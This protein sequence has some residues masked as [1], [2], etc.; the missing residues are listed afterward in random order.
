[1]S[2]E[3]FASEQRKDIKHQ[4]EETV[5]YPEFGRTLNIDEAVKVQFFI[6]DQ[7]KVRSEGSGER[8][9]YHEQL[10][11]IIIGWEIYSNYRSV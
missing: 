8:N 10:C 4:I 3:K 7:G 1:M 2:D 5:C 6:D 9:G 11:K